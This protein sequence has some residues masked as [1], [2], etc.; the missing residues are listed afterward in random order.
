[1]AKDLHGAMQR[2]GSLVECVLAG[3]ETALLDCARLPSLQG[4]ACSQH[5][6]GGLDE[7]CSAHSLL[8]TQLPGVAWMDYC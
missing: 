2:D 4:A 5:A 8:T 6:D 1:M 7:G 3:L